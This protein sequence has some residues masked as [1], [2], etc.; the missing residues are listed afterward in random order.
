MQ[1]F[2]NLIIIL[3]VVCVLLFLHRRMIEKSAKDM[4]NR[5][6]K[7]IRDILEEQRDDLAQSKKPIVWIHIPYEYNARNWQSFGSRNTYELNQPY[8]YVT[9]QS[10]INKCAGDFRICIIDDSAFSKLIP[11][12]QIDMKL[13]SNPISE[14]MRALGMVKLLYIY[15]GINL[16]VSFLCMRDML[17][18]YLECI[19]GDKPFVSEN[20]DRNVTSSK[21]SFYPNMNF[22]GAPRKNHTIFQLM[23]FMQRTISK[24]FTAESV[25]VGDFDRWIEARM[26]E[27]KIN[28]LPGYVIGVKDIN[29]E[30]VTVEE[31]MGNTP[32]KFSTKMYG[33]WIPSH[34]LLKRRKFEW[35]TRLSVNQLLDANT[36]LSKYIL[37]SNVLDANGGIITE[38]KADPGWVSFWDVPSDAPVWG[39][40]P[41]FLGNNLL[42]LETPSY[43][44]N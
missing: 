9:I 42:Q 14:K 27:Q 4:E 39:L 29:G 18:L 32:L 37:M 11:D 25:F 35:F 15:G 34:D 38:L 3:S 12:W 44:G 1:K 23:E 20:V 17:P 31:L 41:D 40:K 2:L 13:I 16:P 24:D 26:R 19:D 7:A 6:Y 21:F 8:L 36:I 10:I 30:P 22:M 33:I 5:D 43:A 28:S